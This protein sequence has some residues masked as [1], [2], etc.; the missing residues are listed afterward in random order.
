MDRNQS[1]SSL[2]VL[3]EYPSGASYKVPN[4]CAFELLQLRYDLD[5]R[6]SVANDGDSL[7]AVVVVV[8]PIR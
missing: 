7:V 6:G 8:L 5:S 3:T 2:A 1:R 4:L